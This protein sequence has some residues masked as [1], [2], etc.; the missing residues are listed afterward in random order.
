MKDSIVQQS[1]HT[2][3]CIL[4][5]WYD[6]TCTSSY[7]CETIKGRFSSLVSVI[8][9]FQNAKYV[10]LKGNETYGEYYFHINVLLLKR[11]DLK[12]DKKRDFKV[13]KLIKEISH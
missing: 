7:V 6:H 10:K 1:S 8:Y 4:K 2:F 12:E 13:D 3:L 9:I 5:G 11:E